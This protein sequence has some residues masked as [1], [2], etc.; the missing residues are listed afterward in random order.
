MENSNRENSFDMADALSAK[1][2]FSRWQAEQSQEIDD[3]ILRQRKAELQSLVRQVIR[4]E[5]SEPDR[6]LVQLHWYEGA[7]KEEIAHM[8]GM[9]R[10]AVYRRFEKINTILYE[11]LK[12]AIEYRYGTGS[13]QTAK[14][15]IKQC[16]ACP[17]DFGT[18]SEIGKRLYRLR[19]SQIL[20][21]EEVGKLTGIGEKRLGTIEKNGK[22]MT[23]LE[24]K[25]LAAFYKVSTDYIIFGKSR[26]LRD[27]VTGMPQQ[28][29][30]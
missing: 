17:A 28:V 4:N 27:P 25:K 21:L 24:V 23:M 16:T 6:R 29:Q 3:Y 9:S 13:T 12:Y 15:I 10:S 20:T 22:D 7:A 14:V 2:V 30:C 18:L 11:K 1:E 5:L 8:T 19:E 26:I